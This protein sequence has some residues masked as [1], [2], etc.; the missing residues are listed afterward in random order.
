MLSTYFRSDRHTVTRSQRGQSSAQGEWWPQRR[1][2]EGLRG[3][4]KPSSQEPCGMRRK[5]VRGRPGAL[6][7]RKFTG[8]LEATGCFLGKVH[9]WFGLD[10]NRTD[11]TARE[12]ENEMREMQNSVGDIEELIVSSIQE[13]QE[14]RTHGGL[15]RGGLAMVSI[16]Q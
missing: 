7:G 11:I 5:T 16:C 8:G 4:C 9:S 14:H 2:A 12:L 1:R 3:A 6:T 10:K 13:K 15:Q